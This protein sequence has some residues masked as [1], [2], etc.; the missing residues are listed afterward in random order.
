[1]LPAADGF[2]LKPTLGVDQPSHEL[3]VGRGNRRVGAESRLDYRV[4]TDWS[5]HLSMMEVR[6]DGII[7]K[8]S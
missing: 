1:V 8:P 7:L 5:A 4:P 3:R 2:D 6:S